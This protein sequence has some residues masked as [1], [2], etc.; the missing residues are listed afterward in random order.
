M[1]IIPHPPLMDILTQVQASLTRA[2]AQAKAT[3][4]KATQDK[5]RY[6]KAKE[7]QKTTFRKDMRK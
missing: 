5:T 2:L 6:D 3:Q 1:K 7:G 4:D